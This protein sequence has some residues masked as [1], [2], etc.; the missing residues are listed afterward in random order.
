MTV[1]VTGDDKLDRQ[2]AALGTRGARSVNRNAVSA[3]LTVIAKGQ[4][5]EAPVGKS[6]ATKKSVGKRF[7]KRRKDGEHEAK[8]GIHVGKKKRRPDGSKGSIAPH[9]HLTALKT[10]PRYTTSGAFRGAVQEN[11]WVGRGFRKSKREAESRVLAKLA[12]GIEKQE[13]KL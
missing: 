10:A 7:Q 8:A 3:G 4:R 13:A 6:R 5:R 11:D 12:E 2:L 1:I 9:A